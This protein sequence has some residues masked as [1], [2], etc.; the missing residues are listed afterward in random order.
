VL[1]PIAQVVEHGRIH[2][3]LKPLSAPALIVTVWG[4]FV[5]MVKAARA[6]YFTLD[7]DLCRQIEETSWDAIA[8]SPQPGA[9][10]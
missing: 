6:G 4:A 5:G 3:A 1:A 10:S 9:K 7:D 2:G 8:A